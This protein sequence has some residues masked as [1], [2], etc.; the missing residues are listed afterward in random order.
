MTADP[1]SAA[2]APVQKRKPAR[3][4]SMPRRGPANRTADLETGRLPATTTRLSEILAEVIRGRGP[5]PFHRFMELALY[6]PGHGYYERS[7][8][9]IGRRGDYFT[10]VSVGSLFGELL[11][12]A[13]AGW[14]EVV[15][16]DPVWLIEAGA[17]DGRLAA[18]ILGWLDRWAP[19]LKSR[20][21]YGIVEPSAR[22]RGWQRERLAAFGSRVRW[23]ESLTAVGRVRPQGILFAN[24]LLDALP[25][26]RF[27]WRTPPGCWME[28]RV[29]LPGAEP[30]DDP[31]NRAAGTPDF[32]WTLA[33]MAELEWKDRWLGEQRARHRPLEAALPD[34][35]VWEHGSAAV[36]WW[37]EAAAALE[38]GWLMAIDY[39][40]FAG[41]AWLPERPRGTLRA[42]HSH[43]Q[44][45]QLLAQP[46]EQDLTADV[47]FAL[48]ER[49]GHAAGWMTE[50][51]S[52]QGRFLTELAARWAGSL[53][54]LPRL[55]A[56]RRR[57]LL[58]LV[59]P[60]H[61]GGRFHIL[62]QRHPAQ[63]SYE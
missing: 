24:E 6:H 11:A 36:A 1:H 13:F 44:S 20:L 49:V 32:Q 3:S 4:P 33:E 45:S 57:Q 14:L 27:I 26:R 5:L 10:S 21:H 29:D 39:G 15:D 28:S 12:F 7:P 53:A 17:H 48:L 34:G 47:D 19:G 40:R 37:E 42:F 50:V 9:S 62:V 46:G 25:I 16:A 38:R 52:N 58:T 8:D 41:S 51:R 30:Q 55:D 54:A 31:G 22:R 2:R 60:E 23:F 35:F 18:D 61:L 63:R 43:H 56:A 59:H